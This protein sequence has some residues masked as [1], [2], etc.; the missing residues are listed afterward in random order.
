MTQSP[1]RSALEMLAR[2]MNASLAEIT[3][4]YERERDA[5]SRGATI[6]NYV[7]LL[8]VRRVRYQLQS[9]SRH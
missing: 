9:A 6:T 2:D 1:D 3:T 4:L 8:A 5:L 7:N